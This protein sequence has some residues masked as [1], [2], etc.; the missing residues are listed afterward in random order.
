M[1]AA[2]MGVGHIDRG[3]MD[4]GHV[5]HLGLSVAVLADVDSAPIEEP[6]RATLRLLG[7]LTREHSV[8]TGDIET[9][10]AARASA[11]QIEDALT[12]AFAFN[13]TARLANAFD[14][15]VAEPAA[16][17]AGAKHLLRRGYR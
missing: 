11:Q 6:L 10:L 8:T 1:G 17:D 9:V 3:H 12:V 15:T 14:F 13:V 2:P 7:K 5:G 16:M 4:S